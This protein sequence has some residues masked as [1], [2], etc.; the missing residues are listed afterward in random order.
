MNQNAFAVMGLSHRWLLGLG[1]LSILAL[2]GRPAAAQPAASLRA[3]CASDVSTVCAG[4]MPGG[5]RIKQC[6]IDKREQLSKACK[7]ALVA[8]AAD[9]KK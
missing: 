9:G 3:A 8:R 5:G 1:L 2:G 6:M 7:D 4:V